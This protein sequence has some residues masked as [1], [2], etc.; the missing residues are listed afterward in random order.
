MGSLGFRAPDHLRG[1]AVDLFALDV[2]RLTMFVPMPH[3]VPWGTEKI[4][5]LID[6]AARDFPLPESGYRLSTDL[7]TGSAGVL[8]ALAALRDGAPTLS[9]LAP[10]VAGV[11]P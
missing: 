8:L 7:G 9:F 5:T 11:R 6:V 10:S 4:R 3:V 1:P 2:L